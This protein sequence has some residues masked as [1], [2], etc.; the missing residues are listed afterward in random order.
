MNAF[1]GLLGFAGGIVSLVWLIVNLIRKKSPKKVLMVFG[2]SLALFIIGIM[3]TPKNT[4]STPKISN[5]TPTTVTES[6]LEEPVA[7]EPVVAEPVMKEAY[8][9][10]EAVTASDGAT[11][12]ISNLKKSQG[13]DYD[14][15]KK[16]M[17]FV[18]VTV[19]IKNTGTDI[20][21]YNR[22]D[23]KMQNSKGQ[24]TNG[25]FSMV[26]N[27]T[28]LDSGSLAV[29]GSVTGTLVYEQPKDDNALTLIY[30]GNMFKTEGVNIKLN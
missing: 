19:I 6:A 10:G 9:L 3:M 22:Y 7:V 5:T 13:S 29:G 4:S 15:P 23:Y 11:L 16:G 25:T 20:I 30:T 14:R 21:S 28:A 8:A 26:N 1:I 18:M 17:E 12:V 24:I 2:G 27:D